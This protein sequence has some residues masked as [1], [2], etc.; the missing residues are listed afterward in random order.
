LAKKLLLYYIYKLDSE[1]LK[2]SNYYIVL[3]PNQA[4]KNGELVSIGDSQML[5]SLRMI[6]GQVNTEEELNKLIAEKKKWKT[7]EDKRG[8]I[9]LYDIENKIDRILFVPEIISLFVSNV[10]HYD[11]IIKNGLFINN[12]KFVRLMCSAG[13]ARR[14]NVLFVDS[15]YEF[16]LKSVLNNNRKDIEITP[17]KFN[18]YFALASSTALSVTTPYFCVVPDCVVKRN[19][20][21][22]WV[23]EIDGKDDSI[24]EVEKELEFNLFDGQGLISPRMAK[25]W[26]NDLDINYIPSCFIIR[27]NFIKGMVA[28][29]DFVK[30]S[31]EVGKHIVKDIYGND[32]NIRDMDVI[33]TESQFKLWNAFDSLSDY[34]EKCNKNNLGWGITRCSPKQENTHTFL[35][36]QFLQVLKLDKKQIESLCKKTVEYFENI[37][38][39]NFDYTLLYLLGDIVNREFDENIF[40]KINDNITKALILEPS[41]ISD[42][43][44]QKHI[45]NSIRKKIKDSYIGNILVDG[46]YSFMVSDPYAF[47][48]YLFG[49]EPI[50]LLDRNEHY[51]KYWIDEGVNEI[52]GMRSPLTWRSE[53]SILNLKNNDRIQD[54][55][56]YLDKCVVFNVHGL[57]AAILGGSDWDGDIICLTNQKEVIDG[58]Y[59][60]LPVMYETHKA[61]KCK[62]VESE[63]YKADLKG[64]NTK[65]GFLTNLSTTMYSM[66]PK[67]KED[68]KEYKEIIRRLK[69][70][71]KEQGAIIDSTKGLDIKPIPAHWTNWTKISDDMSKEEL[72]V[73]SFNNSILID[74][75]PQFMQHLYPNYGKNYRQYYSDYDILAQ[76]K[77]RIFLDELLSKDYSKLSNTQKEFIEK[78][79]KYNP[80]LDTSCEVNNISLHMQEKIKC[81]ES[82]TKLS[83]SKE[84]VEPMKKKDVGIWDDS[85]ADYIISLHKKYK[86]GK[87]SFG[88]IKN[89]DGDRLQTIEQYNKSIRREAFRLSDNLGELA[90]Y[91]IAV[92]YITLE[93]DNKDFVWSIFSNGII[94]NLIDNLGDKIV[95]IPF[96]DNDGDIQYLGKRYKKKEI[97]IH[98]EEEY[99]FL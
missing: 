68:S 44:I 97:K 40:S 33:L 19:E 46:Q 30:F 25:V 14:N 71:R 78:F 37:L 32:V 96:L 87:R 57:D 73:A 51:N 89:E 31:D 11:K 6:K 99:G 36:Y 61:P 93:N 83:W 92:C 15:E 70:C 18:A 90:Y 28:T 64:F 85:K 42:P 9:S 66:L 55:Y 1:R 48:E 95:E 52:A 39:R 63:L 53:V 50:G 5:R 38:S 59:G 23:Q 12:K 88:D 47:V 21:V 54:W 65:V 74:K 22:E 43:Y 77:F 94:E 17:A 2:A 67:F 7:Q 3:T 34:L 8:L 86:I 4:R 81:I 80:L 45:Q 24:E 72:E 75:R 62:I 69:Q 60:G 49:L 84:M 20:K 10:K 82:N 16:R 91:A 79:K 26:A 58:S 35:N 56:K 29:F 98:V 41:L 13:Q 27:S 76:A